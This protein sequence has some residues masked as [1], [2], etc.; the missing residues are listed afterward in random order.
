M[1]VKSLN[2]DDDAQFQ[3]APMIDMVF[4][5][6][7]FFMLASQLS[8][9]QNVRLDMPTAASGVVPEERPDRYI[10]NITLDGQLY[11]GMNEVELADLGDLVLAA[12]EA[13]P[14]LKV[15]LRADREAP[16]R[17]IRRVLSAMA[18]VGIDDFI[19]GVYTPSG[20]GAP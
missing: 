2:E 17:E 11:S 6:L 4:L 9:Q 3:M 10:V 13:N 20:G 8:Q 15:S 18:E 7:V 14:Q 12:R 5:L 16:Y 1:K 19:F